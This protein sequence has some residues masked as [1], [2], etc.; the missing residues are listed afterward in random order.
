MNLSTGS[1]LIGLVAGAVV[2]GCAG[3]TLWA[4]DRSRAAL[5]GRTGTS[6]LTDPPGWFLDALNR[7]SVAVDPVRAWL[8]AGPLLVAGAVLLVVVSLPV[9]AALIVCLGAAI[10]VLPSVTRRR[11]QESYC[12]EVLLAA[13]SLAAALA[14][15][16]ALRMALA[17]VAERDGAVGAD[18]AAA[19]ARHERGVGLQVAI[20]RWAADRPGTGVPL[21]ADALALASGSGGSRSQAVAGVAATLRER[22][23]LARELRALGAQ[24]RASATV[25]VVAPIAFAF[26]VAALDSRVAGF[27]LGQ[28]LGWVCA[29]AGLGLD[30]TGAWWIHRLGRSLR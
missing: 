23:A 25:M 7:S 26:T 2:A 16:A 17:D 21:L 11:D 30:A 27:L 13:E 3:A 6:P 1:A 20:D 8:V 15:G 28:P 14:A 18:I 10:V 4:V 24:S 9:G 22:E 5:A 29:A 19:L 12:R